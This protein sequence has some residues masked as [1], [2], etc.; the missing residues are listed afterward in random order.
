MHKNHGFSYISSSFVIALALALAA[1]GG[2]QGGGTDGK[3]TQTS[4]VPVPVEAATAMR[5]AIVASYSGT[6]A[7]E[8][9]N[10]ALVVAKASGVLLRLLVEEGDLVKPGTLLA[11]LDPEKPRLELARADANL[12]RLENDY[13][14]SSDLFERKLISAEAHERARFDLE[15]Q[16]AVT[17]IARL[18][19]DYTRI[20][21]P[22]GGVISA[23]MVKEGNLI[24]INQSLFRID[25]FDPLLAVLNVPERELMTMQPK[26]GVAMHVD[27]LPGEQFAG[28][29]A[30]VS[31]VVDAQTGTFRV[32]TEFRDD[33]HRL[34]SGM[35]GR[36]DI[37]YDQRA[38]AL[39]VP[40]DAL[41]EG[42]SEAAVFVL[43]PA[44][45]ETAET[46]KEGE[47]KGFF[48]GLFGGKPA[49]EKKPNDSKPVA[50]FLAKRREVKLGYMS[51]VD[52]EVTDG[53]KDGD[54]VVTVGKS[55]L[56]D[57]G[58][59]QIVEAGEQ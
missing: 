53:L 49:A 33:T 21:A 15:T 6:A 42:D 47:K 24:Q 44:P 30:R 18:E 29:V 27:A 3:K 52:A 36:V 41:L 17:D 54:R 59:V 20:V 5:K 55:A 11:Q 7:L 56:R 57:G 48:E 13:R 58:K 50:V 19:L 35:F 37:V 25:D 2:P 31:P 45:P 14:R 9:E 28:V 23:R 40:R 46:S 43:E 8:P 51:G 32:T 10:Q 22:I 34:K 12:K 26:L 1:C 39:V 38:D 16:K 4:D